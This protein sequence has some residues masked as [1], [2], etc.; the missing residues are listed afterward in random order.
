M[1]HGRLRAMP[2]LPGPRR[3]TGTRL[4]FIFD[5]ASAKR[6]LDQAGVLPEYENARHRGPTY[7]VIFAL[8]YGLGLRVGELCQL[9]YRDVDFERR[10]LVIRHAKFG[11]SRLVPFGAV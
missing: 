1:A 2:A 8:L 7:R 10:L 3:S 6:L 5:R 4:P 9:Q 11:K